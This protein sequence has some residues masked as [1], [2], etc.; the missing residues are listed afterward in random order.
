M[1]FSMKRDNIIK[2]ENREKGAI[3]M[4]KATAVILAAGKGTRMK[5]SLPKVLHKVCGKPMVGHVLEAAREAGVDRNILVIGYGA[6]EVEETLGK[7]AEYTY[8]HEQ[9]GTGHA[10]LQAKELLKD[11]DGPVLIICGDTPLLRSETLAGLLNYHQ[12]KGAV[13]TVLTAIMENPKGYGR[14]IRSSQ[15]SVTM[16]VE[17]KDAS[18]EEKQVREINTG[19]YCFDSKLLFAALEKITPNNAQNEYYLTDVILMFVER[20][21]KV[22][23]VIAEDVLETMGVNSRKHLAEAE[24]YLGQ[25]IL[26]KL[27][28]D[29]VTIIDPASTFIQATVKIG[30]DTLIYPFTIIE[31]E[32]VIGEECVIGPASRISA[33]RIGD[34]TIIE[35]STVLESTLGDEVKVGPYAYL[36]PGTVAHNQVKIGDFVEIKKSI[37]GAKSKIPHL[38]YIGD[39]EIGSEVNIG[40]GTITCN[41]DGKNKFKTVIE[42]Q[43]FIGSNSNLVAPVKIGEKA[44]VAAGST[45]SKDVPAKALGVARAKQKNIEDWKKKEED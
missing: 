32:T 10:V 26:D 28:D 33:S 34:R 16:I 45:V 39:A 5:S 35:H 2:G 40:A 20:N 18:L 44:F 43:A 13:A 42:D 25:R 41:Y 27:M 8:Q 9:L 1:N 29:G 24:Q 6:E 11:Y 36:R 14:I 19:T 23:A 30:K 3:E 37:I 21:L 15:G 22:E 12:Q 31:G 38:T 17:E 7:Q 4:N